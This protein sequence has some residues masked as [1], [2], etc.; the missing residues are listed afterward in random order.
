[1]PRQRKLIQYQTGNN[2]SSE[3]GVLF[4]PYK[5]DKGNWKRKSFSWSPLHRSHQKAL[6]E[7]KLFLEVESPNEVETAEQIILPPVK[8]N[9]EIKG[10]AGLAVIRM[11]KKDGTLVTIRVKTNIYTSRRLEVFHPN[12]MSIDERRWYLS[13]L[14]TLG[15]TQI[16]MADILG[17]STTTIHFD[18]KHIKMHPP[19]DFYGDEDTEC[20][21]ETSLIPKECNE[22]S[23]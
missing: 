20:H 11:K 10:G 1:M 3:S 4:V 14:S 6:D 18:L 9:Y 23:Y 8:K 7:A 13:I 15:K 12:V 21:I 19:E 17:V 16:D 22:S 2:S 5:D